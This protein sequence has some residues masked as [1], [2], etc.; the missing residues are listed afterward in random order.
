MDG[1]LYDPNTNGLFAEKAVWDYACERKV[2]PKA[3]INLPDP[4]WHAWQQLKM[5]Y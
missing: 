3:Y 1:V 2:A 4:A 5:I